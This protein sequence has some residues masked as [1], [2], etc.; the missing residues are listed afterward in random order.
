MTHVISFALEKTHVNEC[1]LVHVH[2]P[3]TQCAVAQLEVREQ[4]VGT[5]C[6]ST[7]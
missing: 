2:T 3:H 7:M 6:L 4:L 5:V 1:V